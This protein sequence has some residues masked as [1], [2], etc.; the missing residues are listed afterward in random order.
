MSF[1]RLIRPFLFVAAIAAVP[2]LLYAQAAPATQ[3][4]TQFYMA[5]RT[6]F[7]KATKIEDLFPYMTAANVKQAQAAPAD[8]RTQ[9]FGMMKMLSAA[10]K[11][12]K[13]TKETAA[14]GGGA[15]LTADGKDTDSGKTMHGT[16]KIVREGGALKLSDESWSDH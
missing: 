1:T 15:T 16:I 4:A 3:T 8:Q 7:D 5:Y 11:D 6:A 9:Y 12:V 14:S 13:V 10:V 2:T